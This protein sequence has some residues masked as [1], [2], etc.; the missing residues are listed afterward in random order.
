[1]KQHIGNSLIDWEAPSGIGTNECTL[2]EVELQKG[3]VELVQEVIGVEHG[4]VGL[5][6]ELRVAHGPGGIYEGLPLDLGEHV[7][8]EVGV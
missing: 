7:S 8:E 6:R 4:R 1:M 2:L 3:V 5:L